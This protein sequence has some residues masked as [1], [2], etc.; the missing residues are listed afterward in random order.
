M[1]IRELAA[2]MFAITIVAGQAYASPISMEMF[3]RSVQIKKAPDGQ[4]QLLIDKK[5]LLTDQYISL[6]EMALVDSVPTLV[7]EVSAGGNACSGSMFILSFPAKAAVK[8]DGPLDACKPSQTKIEERMVT[9]RVVPT[10]QTS[11]SLWTWTPASG[12]SVETKLEFAANQNDGWSAL[13]SRSVDHPSTIFTYADLGRLIDN[14][15]GSAK[16]SLV[17]AA[18]GPGSVKYR[19]NLLVARSC[20]AHSCD[21]TDLLIVMDISS[22]RAFVALKDGSSPPLIAPKVDNWPSAARSELLAFRKKWS[23]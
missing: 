16:S 18:S 22:K 2:S 6:E 19:D 5:L 23:R 15:V 21:D 17:S 3:G 20:R 13:R 1:M 11:G 12:F 4:E 7:G 9:V 8:I 14:E 10:P